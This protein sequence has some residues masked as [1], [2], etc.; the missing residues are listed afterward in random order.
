MGSGMGKVVLQEYFYK[1]KRIEVQDGGGGM[2]M[3]GGRILEVDLL[4]ISTNGDRCFFLGIGR[5]IEEKGAESRRLKRKW[6]EI[7]GNE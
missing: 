4:K 7:I 6:W 5:E 1:K 2:K 3:M